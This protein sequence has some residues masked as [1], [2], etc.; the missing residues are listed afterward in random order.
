MGFQRIFG[1]SFVLESVHDLK[2]YTLPFLCHQTWQAGTAGTSTI[3]CHRLLS[4]KKPPFQ[5]SSSILRS[6][7]LSLTTAGEL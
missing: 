7:N 5:S 2:T 4:I 6:L 1:S 3:E